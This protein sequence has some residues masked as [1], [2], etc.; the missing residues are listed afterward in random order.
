MYVDYLIGA[1]LPGGS[2][3]CCAGS[4]TLGLTQ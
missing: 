2:A 4:L 3:R 1:V